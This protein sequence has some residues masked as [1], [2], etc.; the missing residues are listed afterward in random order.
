MPNRR[1]VSP[2]RPHSHP[3]TAIVDSPSP[4]PRGGGRGVGLATR[5]TLP[6]FVQNCRGVSPKRPHSH[7]ATAIVDSPSPK[8]RGGGRGVGLATRPLSSDAPVSEKSFPS[9]T[10]IRTESDTA[11]RPDPPPTRMS[12]RKR[13]PPPMPSHGQHTPKAA[14]KLS[15]SATNMRRCFRAAWWRSQ[16]VSATLRAYSHQHKMDFP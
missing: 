12:A 1:G 7:P 9:D 15:R 3:A 16:R 10:H 6:R 5:A 14:N 4:K 2:K 11:D 13:N 8:P